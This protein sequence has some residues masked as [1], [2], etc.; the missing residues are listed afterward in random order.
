MIHRSPVI[1]SNLA[2]VAIRPTL[3]EIYNSRIVRIRAIRDRGNNVFRH[4][5]HDTGILPPPKQLIRNHDPVR[6]LCSWAS[7]S[8]SV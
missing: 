2:S 6:G 3:S 5:Q 7:H 8:N 1:L 4:Q